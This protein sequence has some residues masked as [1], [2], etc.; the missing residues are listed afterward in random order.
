[1][2]AGGIGVEEVLR[3]SGLQDREAGGI[4][5]GGDAVLEAELVRGGEEA[6]AVV[7]EEV[8]LGGGGGRGRGGGEVVERVG[9]EEGV[10]AE[11]GEDGEGG[12]W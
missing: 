8:E 4:G 1:M 6:V 10:A 11:G 3:E 7:G 5:E 12:R 9:E 2:G